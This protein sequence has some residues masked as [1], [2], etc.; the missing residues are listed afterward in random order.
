MKYEILEIKL[1]KN[2]LIG[3]KLKLHNMECEVMA[4]K[5]NLYHIRIKDFGNKEKLLIKTEKREEVINLYIDAFKKF[6]VKEF[7]ELNYKRN[8]YIDK[9]L[10]ELILK[11]KL[12]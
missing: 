12:D 9:N 6:P 11:T 3:D 8:N 5:N 4:K 10:D 7:N 1:N 2:Y